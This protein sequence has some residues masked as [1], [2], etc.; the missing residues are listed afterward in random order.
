MPRCNNYACQRQIT[1]EDAKKYA[2]S[3]RACHREL[4]FYD[5]GGP[6]ETLL[7][8]RDEAL[9]PPAF[10]EPGAGK[11]MP[12]E[13]LLDLG[14]PALTVTADNLDAV[15]TEHLVDDEDRPHLAEC[16]CW[17]CPSCGNT[18]DGVEHCSC[19][20]ERDRIAAADLA[21]L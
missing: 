16:S 1:Q 13:D 6:A 10:V 15:H 4:S 11:T 14:R 7:D 17:R 8:L 3:C 2:G 18:V 12:A 5:D 9:E 20:L 21:G 19:E